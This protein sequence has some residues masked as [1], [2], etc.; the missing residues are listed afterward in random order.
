MKLIRR[1]KDKLT[2]E[3][4][5]REEQTLLREILELF[6]LVPLTQHRLSRM[7]DNIP[8]SKANQH[9]LEESLKAHQ[10]ET[11][12]WVKSFLKDSGRFE[13]TKSGINFTAARSEIEFL[14]QV[15]ND[16]RIGSWL[17]LGSPEMEQVV[18]LM[19][20][21]QNAV[22]VHRMELAGLFE[23]FF[24]KTISGWKNG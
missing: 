21:K 7:A 4:S 23:S 19:I 24:M 1:Q 20:N 5:V 17:L 6:P 14:L 11:Q 9:L 2:Y 10:A 22:L 12:K 3:F 13:T 18:K 16:I 15:L 8:D